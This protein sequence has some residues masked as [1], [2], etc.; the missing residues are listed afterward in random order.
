[1]AESIPTVEPH[2][3]GRDGRDGLLLRVPYRAEFVAALKTS[4]TRSHRSWDAG[5]G[6]WWIESGEQAAATALVLRYFRTVAVLGG[7][8][9][10]VQLLQAEGAAAE[11]S[12][13]PALKEGD[14]SDA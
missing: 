5:V 4:R 3:P 12:A 7:A 13:R 8:G 10:E 14:M 1:M 6:A 11:V 9:E 2:V